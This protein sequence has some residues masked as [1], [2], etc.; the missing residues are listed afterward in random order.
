MAMA[1]TLGCGPAVVN[2]RAALLGLVQP[3]SVRPWT[4]EEEEFLEEWAGRRRVHWIARKLGRTWGSVVAKLRYDKINAAVQ[5]GYTLDGLALG[6]GVEHR[7]VHDWIIKGWLKA[8]K[9]DGR[10][11]GFTD[12]DVLR[13]IREHRTAFRLSRVDQTWFLDLVLG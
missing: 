2:R 7:L 12:A 4:A 3:R 1:R 10:A 11:Y 8:R 9:R 13:F 6:F 5:E